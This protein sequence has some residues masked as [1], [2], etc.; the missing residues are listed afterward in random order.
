VGTC[1]QNR[2]LKFSELRKED[3]LL[4]TMTS[5]LLCYNGRIQKTYFM[6][7]AH[8]TAF[9]DIKMSDFIHCV[10]EASWEKL[11][12]RISDEFVGNIIA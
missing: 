3:Q 11:N 12:I 4:C 1:Y 9:L 2:E 7:S 6:S 8:V 10:Q 5:C